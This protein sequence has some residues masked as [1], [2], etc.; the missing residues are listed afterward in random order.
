MKFWSE[1][2]F[3]NPKLGGFLFV[4]FALALFVIS[5]FFIF[6]IGATRS[7]AV[8]LWLLSMLGLLGSLTG[9]TFAL[10]TFIILGA[11]GFLI[12]NGMAGPFTR[13]SPITQVTTDDDCVDGATNFCSFI[14]DGYV[15]Y[16]RF[17]A[18]IGLYILGAALYFATE[19]V[20]LPFVG[21]PKSA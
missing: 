14:D 9:N 7:N 8:Y 15:A 13:F 1:I 20:G 12:L 17:L 11:F 21:E 4:V 2:S 5:F 19:A 10:R 16:G 6:S 18:Q 3:R